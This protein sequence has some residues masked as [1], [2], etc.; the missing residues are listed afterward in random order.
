MTDLKF[1]L[2]QLLKNPSFT[3]VAVLTLALG[4]GA[5][6][7]MFSLVNG[8]LLK[9][10]PYPDSDRLVALF[11]NQREQGQDLVGLTAPDF[12]DW[13]AQ[14]T[15]FEDLAAYQPGAFDLTGNGDPARLTGVRASASLFPLLRVQPMLGRAFNPSEDVD[16]NKRVAIIGNQL[17][18]ERFNG[19]H[20]ILSE[21]I[22]LDGNV[23]SI[24]GVMPAGFRFAG[25][26]AEV[27]VPMGFESWEMDN[28]GGH[29][30]Q[31]VGRLKPG[32][33]LDQARTEMAAI[34]GRLAQQYE[35][36]RGWGA[37]L[38]PLR[39]QLVSNS[40]RPLYILFGA[41]S[42]VL[43]IACS[44]I[45]NLLL[46]RASK[47]SREFAIRGALGA[48]R[49]ALIRQLVLESLLLAAAGAVA[50]WCLAQ[51]SLSL[52]LK[53]GSLGLPR[54]EDVRLDGT[55]ALFST[56]IALLTGLAFGAVPA[57]FA[58]R[59]NLS[60]ALNDSA[61]GSSSG[62]G[63]GIRNGF[64]AAQLALALV[65]LIGAGL[66]L[67]SF[68]KIRAVDPGY[69]PDHILT[70][71]LFMPDSRFPGNSF[72]EREPFRKAFIARVLDQVSVL[73]GV[74]SGAVVMGMPL[75][76][77]GG[78][79][80]VL[81]DGRG[82]PKASDP[83]VAGY[84]QVSTNY[85]RTMGISLLKGRDFDGH[86]TVDAPFVAIVN[87]AF[88]RTFFPNED[89][90]GQ[91]LKVM[92]G[93]RDRP[94]E[95][96]GIIRDTRQ[97]SL[98]ARPQAEMYFPIMQRCWFTGQIVLRTKGDPAAMIPSLT[99]AVTELDARQ[100]LYNIRTLTSLMEDS[101]ARQRLQ[102]ILL[103]VFAA[104]ALTLALVGVYGVMAFVVAQRSREIGV[105]MSLGAQRH[106]VLTM[107]LRQTTKLSGIGI[108]IGVVSAFALTRLLRSLLFEVTP[109]D[110]LTFLVVPLLLAV[111][112]LVGGWVPARRAARTNPMEALRNE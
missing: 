36:D 54:L 20:N 39:D 31:A 48:G 40:K 79:M 44:N 55:V 45:A 51:A 77:V 99:K 106:Q 89:P 49:P 80:Q 29:N 60:D 112:A 68:A 63:Q 56:L 28:R 34:T 10:L 87:E 88:A 70:A 69:Q 7:T 38:Q 111:A 19:S 93:Y 27:W 24:I 94:T 43:L 6:T 47:R 75:T 25:I 26:D 1:A 5:N 61:R 18:Q 62:R 17:W 42:F 14:S 107:I 90:I 81:V 2:R 104:V 110:P 15:S 23:Y 59:V 105:R 33:S 92:D 12:V 103:A 82:E 65:L 101:I 58:S 108:V 16:G 67:R 76:Q 66:M 22:T 109:T 72:S 46:A 52:V 3:A 64:V 50:G 96:V 86:D 35:T 41:V 8:V 100:P 37:T 102:M 4:I 95:I 32:V 9:P 71:S 30:Y 53:L 13:R 91:R 11:N 97:Q 73:P 98:T 83:Q 57:W 21:G 78:T 85:F 74:E 84:S